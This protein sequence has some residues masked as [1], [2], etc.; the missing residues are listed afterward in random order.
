M[1]RVDGKKF[2][3]CRW[4]LEGKAALP[5]LSTSAVHLACIATTFSVS[6]SLIKLETTRH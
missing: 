4:T 5:F 1:A 2:G 3:I 6:A